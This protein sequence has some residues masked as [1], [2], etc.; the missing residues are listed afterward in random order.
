MANI[1]GVRN[2][3]GICLCRRDKMKIVAADIHIAERLRN[4]GHVAGNA[5]T[6]RTGRL[7]MGVLFKRRSARAVGRLGTVAIQTQNIHGFS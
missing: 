2:F 7:V 1:A 4:L 6:P 5:F 3:Q